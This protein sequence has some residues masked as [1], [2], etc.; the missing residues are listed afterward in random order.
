[1]DDI[2][3]HP[4][5]AQSVRHDVGAKPRMIKSAMDMQEIIDEK[6]SRLGIQAPVYHLDELIGKGSYG[7][8]FK[9]YGYCHFLFDL[10]VTSTIVLLGWV[11]D[12]IGRPKVQSLYERLTCFC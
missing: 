7:R 5:A 10:L 2:H 3:L 1:M 11:R 8:V 6:A 4:R 12:P 9:R